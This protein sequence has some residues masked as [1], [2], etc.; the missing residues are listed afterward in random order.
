LTID[1]NALGKQVSTATGAVAG[2]TTAA[3]SFWGFLNEYGVALGLIVGII[4]FLVNIYFNRR[5]DNR[6]QAEEDRRQAEHDHWMEI[7]KK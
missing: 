2:G 7:N 6:E 1:A 4:S 5:K 3:G